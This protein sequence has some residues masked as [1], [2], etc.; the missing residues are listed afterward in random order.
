[1][2]KYI[3]VAGAVPALH[4]QFAQAKKPLPKMHDII[5]AADLQEGQIGELVKGKFIEEYKPYV[6]TAADIK[7]PGNK[8]LVEHTGL[9]AGDEIHSNMKGFTKAA[10]VVP[11]IKKNAR[12]IVKPTVAAAEPIQAAE[13]V[14]S[15][16]GEGE[17]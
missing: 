4:R 7:H 6:V 5:D 2:A 14:P 1:M 12:G 3:V 9:E 8:N 11:T 17:E 10:D 13:A 15:V 16:K